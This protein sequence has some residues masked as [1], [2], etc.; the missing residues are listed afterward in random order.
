VYVSFR[1]PQLRVH[2]AFSNAPDEVL[3]A[4]VLFVNGRGVERRLA[5]QLLVSFTLPPAHRPRRAGGGHPDDMPW[6]ERLR[7]EH[8]RFN[9]ARFGGTLCD[10]PVVVS[11]RMR[12]R[13]G[14]YAPAASHGVAEIAISRRLIR[15]QSW[16]EVLDT[17]LHEMVH[18]WQEEEGLAVDHGPAFRN[19][20]REVGTEPR[21]R[22]RPKGRAV[23]PSR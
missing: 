1:G 7:A 13:L 12:T 5:R 15:S 16:D 21:A 9:D 22:K 18:Q 3:A 2:E 23:K 6:A 19:K 11:R 4:I 20:A 8:R 17:L 14:H 10:I